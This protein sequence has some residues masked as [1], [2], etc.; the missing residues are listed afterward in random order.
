[1]F[2]TIHED[3]R[4]CRTYTSNI[5]IEEIEFE[6]KPIC[7]RDHFKICPCRKCII[8]TMCDDGCEAY[9]RAMKKTIGEACHLSFVGK[10]FI[11]DAFTKTTKKIFK[12][13]VY[14]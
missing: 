1:M 10:A 2:M 3:C 6:P 12:R 14:G 4:G 5:S 9:T 11:S 8:K 7:H 13:K